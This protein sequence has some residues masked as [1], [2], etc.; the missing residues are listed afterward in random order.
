MGQS[1]NEAIVM[2]TIRR[3][4]GNKAVGES[5]RFTEDLRLSESSRRVMFSYMMETFTA[6]GV[7]LPA[8]GCYV[9]TFMPCN[10]AGEILGIVRRAF[11]HKAPAESASTTAAVQTPT[12][13]EALAPEPVPAPA[14]AAPGLPAIDP[15]PVPAPTVIAEPVEPLPMPVTS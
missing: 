12:V 5:T 11:G 15:A 1:D 4:T 10:T 2:E 9:S 3:H 7:N 6:R 13:A 8:R 14:P